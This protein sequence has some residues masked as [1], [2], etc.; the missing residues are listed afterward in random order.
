[1]EVVL[2][3]GDKLFLVPVELISQA[4]EAKKRALDRKLNI[5]DRENRSVSV[6]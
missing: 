4:K 5:E 2:C 1:M 3:A 6:S